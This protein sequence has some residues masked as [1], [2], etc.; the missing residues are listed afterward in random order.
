MQE[1]Q[2]R[3]DLGKYKNGRNYRNSFKLKVLEDMIAL[4][5]SDSFIERKHGVGD[6]SL[7]YFRK[8][9]LSEIGYYRILQRMKKRSEATGDKDLSKENEELK[10]AL[11][12][13]MMK[14]QALEVLIDVA[15]D[16]LNVDIRKKGESKQ[17]K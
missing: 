2:E 7:R 4:N 17:S 8:S 6:G 14:V 1:E 11:E 10:K 12:L 5:E 13:A 3:L 15:E 9:I 16:Q